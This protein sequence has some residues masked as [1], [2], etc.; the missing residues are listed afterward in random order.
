M[1]R[2]HPFAAFG[3]LLAG[4]LSLTACEQPPQGLLGTSAIF[5]ASSASSEDIAAALRRDGRVT[6]RGVL[7]EFDSDQLSAEGEAAAARLSEAMMANPALRVAVV[8]HTDATGRFTYNLDLSERR[9]RSLGR[10]ITDAGIAAERVV[11][12]GVGSI[13]PVADNATDAGRAQN[14][15]VEVVV[16]Q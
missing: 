4:S 10:S 5:D 12:V 7:F 1:L 11:P 6:L 13:A 14:R 15:R 8:G 3:L 16:I 9:A 2:S